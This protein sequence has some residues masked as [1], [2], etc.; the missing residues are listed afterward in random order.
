M[1]TVLSYIT[2]GVNMEIINT[3]SAKTRSDILESAQK[4]FIQLGFSG[5]S[6]RK[7]AVGAGVTTGALYCHFRDKNALFEEIVAPIYN[8][9]IRKYEAASNLFFTNLKTQGLN[10]KW[11]SETHINETIIEYIYDNVPMFRLLVN[12]SK[13]SSYENFMDTIIKL[14][15]KTTKKYFNIA[16]IYGYTKKNITNEELYIFTNAQFSCIFQMIL[17]D[18]PKIKVHRLSKN[19]V[20]FFKAGWYTLLME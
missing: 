6:L 3:T 1:I 12:G 7:I 5:A 13:G 2:V 10:S 14:E 4:E 9:F 8:G 11:K 18:I 20:R 16:K 17:H 15:I 19:I